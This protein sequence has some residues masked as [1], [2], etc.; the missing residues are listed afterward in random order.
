MKTITA[1]ALCLTIIVGSFAHAQTEAEQEPETLVFSDT[2]N[3]D[4][5]TKITQF[6]GNVI[7]TRG[8]FRLVA[9]NLDIVEDNEGFRHGTATM[10]SAELVELIEEDL[11]NYELVRAVGLKAEY[12][13][14]TEI[15]KMIG[16][17]VVTRYV[18]GQPVD[19]VRGEQV[20]YDSKN[21]TYKAV[22][23]PQSS[24]PGRVRS[25]VQPRS[26]ADKAFEECQR[27]YNGQPMPSSIRTPEI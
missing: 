22:G 16:Q 21:K 5:I 19:N 12:N 14:K 11:E 24:E 7:L 9:D 4:D 15:V 6:R 23:G 10:D 25:L 1:L 17:A 27:K 18:C 13:G 2:L 20:V 26:K 3:Y 8:L